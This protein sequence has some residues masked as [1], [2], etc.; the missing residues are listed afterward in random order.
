MFPTSPVFQDA[1]LLAQR[2]MIAVI[3]LSSG[4]GHVT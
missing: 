4:W 1:A 3:F 2:L